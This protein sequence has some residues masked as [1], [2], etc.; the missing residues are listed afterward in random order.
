LCLVPGL[1]DFAISQQLNRI[2]LMLSQLLQ[3]ASSGH[4]PVSAKF[5][6]PDVGLFVPRLY[7]P[8]LYQ[9]ERTLSFLPSKSKLLRLRAAK[10]KEQMWNALHT[11]GDSEVKHAR[12]C[13]YSTTPHSAR[14]LYDSKGPDTEKS[15]LTDAVQPPLQDA[16]GYLNWVPTT[17][18]DVFGRSSALHAGIEDEAARLVETCWRERRESR[19][20]SVFEEADPSHFAVLSDGDLIAAIEELEGK[21]RMMQSIL[22]LFSQH[23]CPPDIQEHIENFSVANMDISYWSRGRY[24]LAD[25]LHSRHWLGHSAL[26]AQDVRHRKKRYMATIAPALEPFFTFGGKLPT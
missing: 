22:C 20:G 11:A 24:K 5:I 17:C 16:G 3:W 7:A 1:M 13:K 2:V 4:Q 18:C 8:G 25:S 26:T 23:S 14:C 12:A 15:T 6:T 21:N 9:K 19:R 10:V